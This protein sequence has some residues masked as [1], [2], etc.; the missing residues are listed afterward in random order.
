MLLDVL[1]KWAKSTPH[2][3]VIG[4]NGQEFSYLEFVRAVEACRNYLDAFRLPR[5]TV[6]VVNVKARVDAW[7][8]L[9]AT[10]SLG[11][12]TIV[13]ADLAR[14]SELALRNVSCILQIET[15]PQ[16]MYGAPAYL[17]GAQRIILPAA[18]FRSES[19]FEISTTPVPN[20]GGHIILTSGSTAGPRKCLVT[21]E[22][23]DIYLAEGARFG[24]GGRRLS[25]HSL[26]LTSSVSCKYAFPVWGRGGFVGFDTRG[27]SAVFSDTN[28][29]D[30]AYVP[31]AELPAFSRAVSDK[32]SKP[33]SLNVVIGGGH[34][35]WAHVEGL[36]RSSG[37][38]YRNIYG[39]SERRYMCMTDL[40]SP[41]DVLWHRPTDTSMLEIVDAEG[42]QVPIGA[43][44]FLKAKILPG[45]FDSYMDDAAA[46]HT[47]FRDGYF[48]PGDLA[49]RRQDGRIRIL[50]RVAD[51][52]IV[53]GRKYSASLLE[54]EVASKLHVETVCL[55]TAQD[56]SSGS[57]IFVAIEHD[58]LPFHDDI[59]SVNAMFGMFRHVHFTAFAR[60]PR[61]PNGKVDRL[62][63]RTQLVNAARARVS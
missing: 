6:A 27:W 4:A 32:K 53:G 55:F 39:S 26:A 54:E 58:R 12:T 10:R 62:S 21:P 36:I 17:P 56:D 1:R 42:R 20:P 47:A 46:S 28:L 48:Y 29:T 57:E 38:D 44:G 24:R 8:V 18:A 5:G 49:V 43:E 13:L 14:S 59:K 37:W 60:L 61:L 52:V 9:I 35:P 30:I 45:D 23:E 41:D 33:A 7:V 51:I 63:L 50:G 3:P 31:P 34:L 40:H 25:L 19:F 15:E 22:K 16:D 2:N 11:L